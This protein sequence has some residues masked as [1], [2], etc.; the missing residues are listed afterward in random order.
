MPEHET[1]SKHSFAGRFLLFAAAFVI[2]VA[3][4]R[5]ASS[6]IIPFLPSS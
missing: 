3:G 5:A 1:V 6:L 2:V 4:L